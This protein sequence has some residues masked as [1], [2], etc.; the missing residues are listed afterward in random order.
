[1][2][3]RSYN[4]Y[5]FFSE[6]VFG[7]K[8]ISAREGE[9]YINGDDVWKV[10]S[11][12][13]TVEQ[14]REEDI[15]RIAL[16]DPNMLTV[17][18]MKLYLDHEYYGFLMRHAGMSLD[19]YIKIYNPSFEEK[20]V[21]AKRLKEITEY[22]KKN[23][24]LHGD[25]K[26]SNIMFEKSINPI[27]RLGDVNNIIF[28]STKSASVNNL[29]SEWMEFYSNI[30]VIDKLSCDLVTF[31]LL[32]YANY[33]LVNIISRPILVEDVRKI[34]INDNHPFDESDFNAIKTDLT[35][36]VKRKS[37]QMENTYLVDC[38]K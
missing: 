27:V 18:T 30:N 32:S 37:L 10:F 8:C 19:E 24:L 33:D 38:L 36:K 5:T 22:L 17:P 20:I 7:W 29:S 1:M 26:V 11:S 28:P 16:L 15:E 12:C 31:I 34:L 3:A 35:C 9:I 21:I 14:K 13:L 23:S 4:F 6:I 2:E 25:I